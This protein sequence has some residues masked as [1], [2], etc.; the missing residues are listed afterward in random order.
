MFNNKLKGL[1]LEEVKSFLNEDVD[2]DLY[3]KEDELKANIFNDFLYN[4]NPNLTKRTPWR[5]IPFHRLKK[6]W[7]D[8]IKYGFVRDEKGIDMIEGIV[9]ANIIKIHIFTELSGH[10]MVNP[11]DDFEDYFGEVINS[12]L[13]GETQH[14]P[15]YLV[16]YLKQKVEELTDEDASFETKK[17]TLMENLQ[18]KFYWYYTTDKTGADMISDYGLTPL[19]KLLDQ[20]RKTNNVEEK[21]VTIDKI[22]NVVHQRSDIA[23][24]FIEGGSNALSQISG[25]DVDTEDGWGSQSKISG[26]YKMSDYH[27]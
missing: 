15:D 23:A 20:L 12:F 19:L 7:E 13:N 18:E 17:E 27:E 2:W 21:L 26:Q 6:I 4:N 5:L 9:T 25:Y 3:E 8:Y 14:L 16:N 1:I 10:T 22:L 24:W 11:D